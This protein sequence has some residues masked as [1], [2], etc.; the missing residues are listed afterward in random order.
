[1]TAI[2]CSSNRSDR[3]GSSDESTSAQPSVDSPAAR[4]LRSA[5]APAVPTV[6]TAVAFAATA[7]PAPVNDTRANAQV[8][9]S[10]PVSIGGTLVGATNRTIGSGD[11]RPC[12][13]PRRPRSG[14]ASEPRT[15]SASPST[16]RRGCAGSEHRRLPR[17]SLAAELDH[18]RTHGRQ[19]Q[20]LALVQSLQERPLPDPRC[21]AAEL[22]ARAVHARGL[23][24]HAGRASPGRTASGRGISGQSTR[25]RTST[26][27]TPSRCTPASAI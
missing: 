8:I 4:S 26:R 14:T 15:R 10:L 2:P 3:E 1:M 24:A 23:P 27:H 25:S 5:H 9:H 18:M 17:R 13:D 11:R 12:E 22:A 16:C 6:V 21:R 20:G 19:G 7:V